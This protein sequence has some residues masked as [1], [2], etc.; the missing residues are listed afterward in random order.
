MLLSDI[1]TERAQFEWMQNI[2]L[3]LTRV[4]PPEDEIIS[5]YLILGICKSAAVLSMVCL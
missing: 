5:Q 1:F 4:H 2:M 3:E